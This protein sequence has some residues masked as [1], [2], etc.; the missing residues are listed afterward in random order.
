MRGGRGFGRRLRGLAA[1]GLGGAAGLGP[2]GLRARCG[3]GLV[4]RRFGLDGG[5]GFCG[6]FCAGSAGGGGRRRHDGCGGLA[7]A[8]T[9]DGL[10][11]LAWLELS[12]GRFALSQTASP[13]D[14]A[15][16]LARVAPS[17]ML[18]AEGTAP[19]AADGDRPTTS[20]PPWHF[21]PAS[22][23]RLLCAQFGT[24]DLRGFGCEAL[25]AAVAA[26][27]A[28]LQ[29]V[30]ETQKVPLA[31]LGGLRV[32]AP[33]DTLILDPASR[34]NLEIDRTLAGETD[35]TLLAVLDGCVTHPALPRRCRV[36][37]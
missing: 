7:A 2:V 13:R 29:Y 32:E 27:G 28:L 11:G 4:W 31:H 26:A 34:R 17:E 33:E 16:E 20:R 24:T 5:G 15:A 12:S 10:H 3:F 22:A 21:D 6:G 8:C 25:D 14:F 18:I 30:Q 19:P 1:R 37:C 36:L 23:R 9:L 35:H